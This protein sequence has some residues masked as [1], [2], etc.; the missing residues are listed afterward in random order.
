MLEI[1]EQAGSTSF[2]VLEA[3]LEPEIQYVERWRGSR[4]GEPVPELGDVDVD[5]ARFALV[6]VED[7]AVDGDPWA[8]ISA[9]LVRLVG[10]G[11]LERQD[12][13]FAGSYPESRVYL[14]DRELYDES[15]IGSD[16]WA[17]GWL[18]FQVPADV[19]RGELALRYRRYVGNEELRV[20]WQL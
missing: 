6:R 20:E 3:E 18:V 16:G 5:G 9:D 12:Y 14:E 2:R 15:E 4:S 8:P 11:E 13:R 1:G 19:D 17:R 10:S 7:R